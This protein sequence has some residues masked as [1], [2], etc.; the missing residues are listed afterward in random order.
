LKQE[1]DS[2]QT[3]IALGKLNKKSLKSIP[4]L[5]TPTTAKLRDRLFLHRESVEILI[6]ANPIYF[7]GPQEYQ[8]CT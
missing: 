4:F 1:N 8:P 7:N 6:L 3:G 5:D 2:V